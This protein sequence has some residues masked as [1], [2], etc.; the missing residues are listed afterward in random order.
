MRK[1]SGFSLVEMVVVIGIIG[2]LTTLVFASFSNAKAKSRDQRRISDIAN[3]QLTLEQFYN[4]N[5][6]YPKLLSELV[7]GGFISSI[8]K[9][10]TGQTYNYFP[11]SYTN[12]D[13]TICTS[14]QIWID[15]EKMSDLASSTRKGFNSL[16][17]SGTK[18]T[19]CEATATGVNASDATHNYYDVIQ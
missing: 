16:L 10:P 15:L 18:F 6:S 14:Y 5:K 13:T 4:K 17:L 7:T 19:K 2:L 1:K 11:M 12:G 3:F 9:S 8:P